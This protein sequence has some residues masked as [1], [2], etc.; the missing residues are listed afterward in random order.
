[1]YLLWM[2]FIINIW[3]KIKMIDKEFAENWLEKLKIY[4]FN[5]D[6]DKAC[7]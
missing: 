2:N 6:I 1:M 4:W 5:K 7:N 3:R